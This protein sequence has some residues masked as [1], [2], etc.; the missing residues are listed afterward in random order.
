M[1]NS[2]LA[3]GIPSAQ[4]VVLVFVATDADLRAP[5]SCGF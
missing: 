4:G 2:P 5:V 1:P 3:G